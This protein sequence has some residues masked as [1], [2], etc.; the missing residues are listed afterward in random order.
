MSRNTLVLGG[1]RYFGKH[2]VQLLLDRGDNVYIAS[3][4]N[5]PIPKKCNFIKF[6]RDYGLYKGP[7]TFD[8]V[9]DQSCY[10]GAQICSIKNIILNAGLY[11]LTS[12]QSVYPF[13]E[14][15]KEYEAKI[16]EGVTGYG[17]EKLKAE[18]CALKLT[19]RATVVRF[20]VVIG[21]NDYYKRVHKIKNDIFNGE[22]VIP[23]NNPLLNIIYEV[24]AAKALFKLSEVKSM[25]A[26]NIASPYQVSPK[27]IC[28][29]IASKF[30]RS[31]ELKLDEDFNPSFYS[32]FKR[33]PKTLNLDKQKG[34]GFDFF[35][36]PM[37]TMDQSV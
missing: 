16:C 12:S 5:Y 25:G 1:T 37:D 19:N 31:F 30:N 11:I 29:H 32:I 10:L 9:Y 14:N 15:L 21:A 17:L 23:S 8:I 35:T 20:P 7:V 28:Y 33:H 4:G 13:K 26:I 22:I 3:R 24:D 27:E 18:E 36:D 2:L 34:L 6:D